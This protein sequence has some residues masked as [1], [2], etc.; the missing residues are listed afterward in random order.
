MTKRLHW[1]RLFGITLLDY[2]SGSNYEVELEKDL[3]TQK[4]L[5]DVLIIKR[6][7][8]QPLDQLPDG[9]ENLSKHNLLT[10]KSHHE[11]L[12]SWALKELLGHYVNYRKQTPSGLKNKELLPEANFQLYAVCTRYPQQLIKEV[13]LVK[14]QNGVY[15]AIG[16]FNSTVRIIVTSKVPKTAK[17]TLWQL[18]SGVAALF[19]YAQGR[20]CW[21]NP[22]TSTVV[23]QMYQYYTTEE[24]F[25]PYTMEDYHREAKV[26][27]INQV[28][29]NLDMVLEELPPEEILKRLSPDDIV[30]RLS[31][32]DIVKRLSPET[33]LQGLSPEVI[34]AYLAKLKKPRKRKS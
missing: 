26:F 21:R 8:G 7:A 10:Y 5:L 4:Q 15:E 33:R 1:H 25:M 29:E 32:D 27:L 20:H 18:F 9:L 16:G 17:N 14:I 31:P 30:K 3:S 19:K 28:K 12:D 34:E 2:F 11:P 6:T 13:P 22:K 23:N 24:V